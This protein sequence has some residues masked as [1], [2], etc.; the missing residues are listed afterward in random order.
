MTGVLLAPPPAIARVTEVF[1]NGVALNAPAPA[2][3][4]PSGYQAHFS[5]VSGLQRLDIGWWLWV[6]LLGRVLPWLAAVPAAL[7]WVQARPGRDR[8]R[9]ALIFGLCSLP[10][11]WLWLI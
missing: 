7:A 10:G 2:R 4:T 3:S 5:G 6:S 8:R 1:S 9:T 11:L